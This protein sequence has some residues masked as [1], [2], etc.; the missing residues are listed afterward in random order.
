MLAGLEADRTRVAE[1]DARISDVL[2]QIS[3]PEQ[4]L[5]ALFTDRERVQERLDG[6]K[7]PVLAL[8]NEIVSEIFIQFLWIFPNSP[9][10]IGFLSPAVLT[11]ICRKWREIVLATPT[12]WT[13]IPLSEDDTE[14]HAHISIQY[15]DEQV[16]F[17]PSVYPNQGI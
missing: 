3:D 6:Y 16:P 7:Y 13:D 14:R 9:P 11:H 1:I 5:P 4:S 2:H 12:L 10:L 17:L 15:L 8:P